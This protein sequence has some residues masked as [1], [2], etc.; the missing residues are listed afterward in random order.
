MGPGVRGP[1][2]LRFCFVLCPLLYLIKYMVLK[3]LR[4]SDAGKPVELAAAG[5]VT[6][7]VKVGDN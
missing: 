6:R 7:K 4:D 5:I 1:G 2:R 3:L